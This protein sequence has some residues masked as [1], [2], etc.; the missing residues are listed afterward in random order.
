MPPIEITICLSRD[1]TSAD[2]DAVLVP[3]NRARS[4]SSGARVTV[5]PWDIYKDDLTAI[6]IYGKGPDI[7]QVGATLVNDLVVMNALRPFTSREVANFGGPSTFHAAA[8]QSSRRVHEGHIWAIP[9]L[10]DPRA[11]LYWKD[12]LIQAGIH[13]QTAFQSFDH[14]EHTFQRLQASGI[15]SPWVLPIGDRLLALQ[16]AC[17]WIWGAGGDF[18]SADNRTPFFHHPE[19]ISGLKVYFGLYR[20]MPK[21]SQ[22]LDGPHAFQLFFDRKAVATTG[23]LAHTLGLLNKL[24][25]DLRSQVGVALPPGAPLVGSSSL[26]VW[27]HTRNEQDAVELIRFLL[28]KEAQVQYCQ[29]IGYLP[30]RTD[31]LMEPPYATDPIFRGFAQALQKGRLF[32]LVKLGGLLEDKLATILSTI[33]GDLITNQKIDLD[34]ALAKEFAPIVRR[35]EQ[36]G[37]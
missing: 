23:N 15:A 34:V 35:F 12:L 27:K 36:W 8:W 26:L 11:I 18:V 10:A 17:S 7:S 5:I 37:G 2:L 19:A 31:A 24:P 1:Q 32:P 30:V 22:P 4:A 29:R 3:F 21:D 25:P 9:W 14:M 20:F 6:A 13:E 33:W 16:T 28:T